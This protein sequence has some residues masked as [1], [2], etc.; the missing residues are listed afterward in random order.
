MEQF[1]FRTK[2][3]WIRRFRPSDSEELAEIISNP[4]VC[5]FEPSGVFPREKALGGRAFF[6]GH[7]D[8]KQ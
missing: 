2:R 5:R 4:E 3:L 7:S 1:E 8:R 6:R